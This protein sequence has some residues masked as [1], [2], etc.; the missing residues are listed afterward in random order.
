M[1]FIAELA[2]KQEA[3]SKRHV[4]EIDE[5]FHVCFTD[6]TVFH[7]MDLERGPTC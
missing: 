6:K 5:R 7:V 1:V 2:G 3:V 4:P